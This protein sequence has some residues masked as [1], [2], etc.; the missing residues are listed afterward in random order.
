MYQHS[1][2]APDEM[3]Q[4]HK[5]F[6]GYIKSRIEKTIGDADD[7]RGGREMNKSFGLKRVRRVEAGGERLFRFS[8]A[9]DM[10]NH[11]EAYLLI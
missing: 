11:D 3:R 10:I 5:Q 1:M 9:A 6:Y 8:P 4:L 2:N 7:L